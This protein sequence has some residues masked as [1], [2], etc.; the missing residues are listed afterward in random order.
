MRHSEFDDLIPSSL[1]ERSWITLV[2]LFTVS[3]AA[4]SL[5]DIP[6]YLKAMV[7]CTIPSII[8]FYILI[9]RPNSNAGLCMCILP[10]ASYLFLTVNGIW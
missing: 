7:L 1:L 6:M 8:G 4:L 5:H 9:K 3:T 10:P 2:L